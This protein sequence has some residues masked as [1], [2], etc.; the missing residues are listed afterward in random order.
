MSA[1][2]HPPKPV[3]AIVVLA[4][5]AGLGWWAWH[6]WGGGS[7]TAAATL[8]GAVEARDYQVAAAAAGTVKEV[9]V[10]EG[11]RVSEGDPLVRLDDR[12]AR[13]QVDQARAG[14]TAGRAAV[15]S[16][17]NDGSSADVAAAKARLEQAR[18]A[19]RLARVQLGNLTVAAPH[20]GVVTSITTNAG[21]VAAP[22]RALVTVR[23]T[24]D[25][26]VR[27]FVPEPDL[28]AA[29]IGRGATVTA[30]GS[31]RTYAGTVTFVS[32]SAEFTPN[33]VETKDQR[34]KLVYEVRV[35]VTDTSGALKAGM[36][37]DVAWS[38]PGTSG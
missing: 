1:R 14:V 6:T 31:S 35:A 9:L 17:R 20:D 32:S 7:S 26:F 23:D 37:V 8:T 11:A 3:I 18:A 21:Q 5:L 28:G 33:A 27:V 12:A 30:D 19:V 13:L 15:A 24:G 16:A 38:G 22:G 25:L 10:D 29:T 36:P 4:L 2:K 34:T